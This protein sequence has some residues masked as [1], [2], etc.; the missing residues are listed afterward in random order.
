MPNKQFRQLIN[1]APHSLTM[2]STTNTEFSSAEVWFTHPNSE[3]LEIED[4]VNMRLII[5]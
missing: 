4:N 1:I 3:H 5:G 2:L